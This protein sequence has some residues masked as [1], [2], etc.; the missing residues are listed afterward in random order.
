MAACDIYA[1][2]SRLEGFGMIQVEANACGKP[3]IGIKA[4]GLLDTMVHKQTAFLANVAQEVRARETIVGT[5]QGYEEGHRVVFKR[6]RT[7]DFRASV[8]EIADYLMMLMTD[9]GLRTR[10]GEAGR[11]RV[12][13]LFDYRVVA[14][15]FADIV[16]HRLGVS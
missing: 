16:T 9:P 10:M 15:R 7:V 11:K 8:H 4:M 1:A 13:E 3:V 14:K 12:V 5:D 6:P 2:P